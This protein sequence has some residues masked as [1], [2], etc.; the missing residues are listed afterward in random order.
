MLNL[1]TNIIGGTILLISVSEYTEKR[2]NWFLYLILIIIG[3]G[4]IDII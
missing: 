3:M 4:L 1:I 2:Y